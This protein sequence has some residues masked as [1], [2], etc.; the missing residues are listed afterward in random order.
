MG[1]GYRVDEGSQAC[2]AEGLQSPH[3][4]R[5]VRQRAC[6]A[7]RVMQSPWEGSHN[8]EVLHPHASEKPVTAE[9][10]HACG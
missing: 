6:R 4:V 9:N 10:S 1:E 3:R 8:E 7:P 2:E 5:H